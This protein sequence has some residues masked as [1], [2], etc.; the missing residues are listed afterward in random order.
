MKVVGI[1]YGDDDGLYDDRPFSNKHAFNA[2]HTLTRLAPEYDLRIMLVK[3][4]WVTGRTCMRAWDLEQQK[5][6]DS[7]SVDA[8]WD[9]NCLVPQDLKAFKKMQAFREKIATN[10]PFMDDPRIQKITGDKLET[11]QVFSKFMP[12]TFTTLVDA[13]KHLS[14][15]VVLKPQF[16]AH[17]IGVRIEE[18]SSVSSLPSGYLVQQFVDSSA[19]IPGLIEGVSDLRVMIL[20]GSIFD[21]FLRL[22][23]TGLITNISQGGT[24]KRISIKSIPI[25]VLSIVKEVETKLAS[26][27]PRFYSIDFMIG[28]GKP[29]IIEMNSQPGIRGYM[30]QGID[31]PSFEVLARRI[32]DALVTLCK[33]DTFKHRTNNEF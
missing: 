9:R 23:K 29:W 25:D 15:K 7:I 19:G 12:L 3:P 6:V 20:N 24:M 21:A 8:Y 1:I 30:S 32:L 17:G 14:G 10:V 5:I 27:G 28:V 16:G 2:Y 11:Y 26:L 18:L 13:K 31:L 22:P 33:E 4:E